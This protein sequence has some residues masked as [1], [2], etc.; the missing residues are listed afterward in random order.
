M[1]GDEK[2]IK[3]SFSLL[4]FAI[5][6]SRFRFGILTKE[7]DRSALKDIEHIKNDIKNKAERK[8]FKSIK[9]YFIILISVY[10]N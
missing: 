1:M 8:I 2:H 4:I 7:S 6:K 10:N 9:Q 3:A 5:L